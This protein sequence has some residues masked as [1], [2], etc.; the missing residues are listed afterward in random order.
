MTCAPSEDSESALA[1]AE[2][3][4]SS[5]SARRNLGSLATHRAHSK[6][7]D[8]TGWM[9]SSMGAKFILLVL[10]CSGSNV[11]VSE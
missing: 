6:D 2:S 8:Q 10:S 5:L 7:Y 3:D 9:P 1:S 11:S 4:Q